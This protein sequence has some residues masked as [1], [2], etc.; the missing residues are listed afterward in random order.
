MIRRLAEADAEAYHRLRSRALR[1]HPEAFGR[2]AEEL[3]SVEEIRAALRAGERS[4]DAFSLGAFAPDLVGI[5][6]CCRERG[7]KR[8]HVAMVQGMY[9]VPEARGRTIGRRLVEAVIRQAGTW[10]EVEQL[11]LRVVV[12]NEAARRLYRAC[13]FEPFGLQRRALKVGERYL[14]EE[15]LALHLVRPPAPPGAPP[16]DAI[17]KNPRR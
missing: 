14:D 4:G 16:A 5:V 8:Q 12:G 1:E 9:V 7:R 17:V 3:E 15:Q 13:G 6:S 2:A 10:P 11:W